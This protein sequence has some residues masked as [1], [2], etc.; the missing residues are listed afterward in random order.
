M[1]FRSNTTL[2]GSAQHHILCDAERDLLA[3]AKFLVI[4]SRN[5]A[6]HE[7]P[8]QKCFVNLKRL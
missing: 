1:S 2:K 7:N 8:Q 6:L 5:V 4:G 3:I